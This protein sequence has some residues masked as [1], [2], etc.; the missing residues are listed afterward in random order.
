MPSSVIRRYEYD[1]A[2]RVL[3]IDFTTGRRYL[4][5]DV[6]EEEVEAM[7]AVTSKGRYFNARIRDR[8]RFREVATS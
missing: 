2:E 5:F 1:A 7:R 6:P 8:Y 4:Y 3:A